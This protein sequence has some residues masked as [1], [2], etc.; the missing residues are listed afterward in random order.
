MRQCP[1]GDA[2][3]SNEFF[4]NLLDHTFG[5]RHNALDEPLDHKGYICTEEDYA[6]IAD[7]EYNAIVQVFAENK[8]V[9]EH[10]PNANICSKYYEK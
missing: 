9:F 6:L 7:P 10:G 1:H 8:E 4:V 2:D 5:P 3:I